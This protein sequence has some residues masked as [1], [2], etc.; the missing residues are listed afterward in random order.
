MRLFRA[1]RK[2]YP[3]IPDMAY[4]RLD[5]FRGFKVRPWDGPLLYE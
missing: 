4:A 5:R 1:M 3:K 2:D